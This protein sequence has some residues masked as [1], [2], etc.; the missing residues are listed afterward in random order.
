MRR[1][2]MRPLAGIAL[3]ALLCACGS[4]SGTL[5]STRDISPQTAHAIPIG[6]PTPSPAPLLGGL[7]SPVLTL[8]T[9]LLPVCSIVNFSQAE[10]GA[11]RNLQVTGI[12]DG[13]LGL[14][15]VIQGY[16]PADIQRAYG[17]PSSS[18]GHGQTIGLVVAYDDP[19]A[20]SDLAVYRSRFKLARVRRRTDASGKLR[21]RARPHCPPATS[22]G[23]KRR[24]STS[25]WRLPFARI[26]T[27]CWWK[28]VRRRER[29][30]GRN[31]NGDCKR[32]DGREQ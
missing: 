22:R 3:L 27:C 24:L 6:T 14:L 19:K 26:A 9:S 5:P 8:A 30:D 15:G 18:A 20:E 16:H 2:Y 21:N 28:R 13:L 31:S 23:R 1:V 11:V 12:L 7:L 4:P 25:T 32:R 29:F 10:C 17:F